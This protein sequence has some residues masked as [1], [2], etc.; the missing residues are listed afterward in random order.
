[1]ITG[2]NLVAVPVDD[3][4]Q[5]L[6]FFCDLLGMEKRTDIEDG[7]KRYVEVAPPGSP[8]AL[9]PYTHYNRGPGKATVGE[10][11]RVVLRVADVRQAHRQLSA[12][13]VHFDAEPFDVPHGTFAT[14][15]DPWG[16]LYGITDGGST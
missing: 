9:S 2:I 12:Q 3:I 16:N 4:E 11:S 13:G 1:M 10:Y 7:N 6:H 14:I 5:A 8:V 15:R